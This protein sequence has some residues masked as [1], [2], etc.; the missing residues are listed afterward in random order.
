MKIDSALPRLIAVAG[1]VVA[2]AITVSAAQAERE[3]PATARKGE[4]VAK[5]PAAAGPCIVIP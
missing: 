2:I 5:G 4:A 3:Q 1:I